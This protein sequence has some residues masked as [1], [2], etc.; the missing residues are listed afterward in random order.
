MFNTEV[1]ASVVEQA[2]KLAIIP[3]IESDTATT[4]HIRNLSKLN[5]VRVGFGSRLKPFFL[6]LPKL[7]QK[8]KL[9]S[10]GREH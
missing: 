4:V 6:Q 5:L 8:H 7:P 10:K 2:C 9:A 1:T 3:L